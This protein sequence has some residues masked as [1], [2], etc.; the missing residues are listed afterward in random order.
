[1]TENPFSSLNERRIGAAGP[2]AGK[3]VWTMNYGM[4]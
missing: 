2:L 4:I 1:M 3:I